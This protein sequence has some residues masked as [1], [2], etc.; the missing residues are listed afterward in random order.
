M[1]YL[2][3]TIVLFFAMFGKGYT[4]ISEQTCHFGVTF[5]ISNNPNWG[6]GE[7]VVLTVEPNSPAEAAGIKPGDIIMEINGAATYLRNYQTINSW[8]FDENVEMASFT[9]RNLNTY[10]KEYELP[11]RC[12]SIKAMDESALAS[13]FSFYSLENSQ[14]RA[15]TLPLKITTNK[16]VDYSDYHTFNF[17]EEKNAPAVDKYINAEIEKVLI[18]MGLTR[19][20]DNPDIIVQTYY[21]YQTNPKYNPGKKPQEPRSWRYDSEKKE[22]VL[23]PILSGNDI[24]RDYAG[25]FVLDFGI[26]FFD[27]KYID[28]K[29]PTQI[30][31]GSAKEY[32]TSQYTMEEYAKLHIPL[33]I[34]QFPYSED[35][36]TADY[37]VSFKKYNYTGLCYNMDDLKTITDVDRNS[38]AYNAGLRSGMTIEKINKDKFVYTKSD[39]LAGYKRFIVETMKYRDPYTRFTDANKYPDSMYWNRSDYGKVA[40]AI[41]KNNIYASTFSYLYYFESYISGGAKNELTIETKSK[42]YQIVPDVKSYVTLRAL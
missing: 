2:L 23:L 34:M 39:I 14:D 4:Q 41:K 9:V 33:I 18:A 40:K 19:S 30:W 11:R 20:S 32:L 3:L 12:R 13:S 31:E 26:R 5:E 8:L 1:K 35:R 6:Y 25:Q 29:N 28:P 36:Q 24:A 38:P 22:M 10:F 21:S 16:N 42:V 17:V 7:P 15:F 27:Q 37:L